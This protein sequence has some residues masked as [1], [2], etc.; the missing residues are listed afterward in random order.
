MNISFE[1]WSP[2]YIFY[3][4]SEVL[5]RSSI[6]MC[7]CAIAI[8]SCSAHDHRGIC[9]ATLRFELSAIRFKVL[10]KPRMRSSHLNNEGYYHY[11]WTVM[12]SHLDNDEYLYHT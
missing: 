9:L 5:L 11:T 12:S 7:I 6:S 10:R 4:F 1:V 3:R 2:H 8:S